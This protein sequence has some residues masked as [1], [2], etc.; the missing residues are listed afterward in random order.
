MNIVYYLISFALLCFNINSAQAFVVD[1]SS[2]DSIGYDNSTLSSVKSNSFLEISNNLPQD[3]VKLAAVHLISS[4]DRLKVITKTPVIKPCDTNI[5][6]FPQG[7]SGTF[8]CNSA[9]S[10]KEGSVTKSGCVNCKSNMTLSNGQCSCDKTKYKYNATNNPCLYGY[11][12]NSADICEEYGPTGVAATYYAACICPAEYQYECTETG[13]IGSG[14]GCTAD[15]VTKYTACICGGDYT[16][17]CSGSSTGTGTVSTPPTNSAH[18]CTATDGTKKYSTCGTTC[19]NGYYATVTDW[20]NQCWCGADEEMV[21]FK[22]DV[23]DSRATGLKH[24][25][26][27]AG[28]ST[29]DWGDGNTTTTSSS[30]STSYDHTYSTAGTYTIKITGTPTAVEGSDDTYQDSIVELVKVNLPSVISYY[31]LFYGADNMTGDLSNVTLH[32]GLVNIS[33]MFTG[34]KVTGTPP[35]LPSSVENASGTYNGA[36]RLTCCSLQNNGNAN[37]A[38]SEDY[39]P[40]Y[41]STIEQVPACSP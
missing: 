40:T 22:V 32:E 5:Y 16:L 8:N 23:N 18:I 4:P 9:Q 2:S 36:C 12:Q 17:T 34:S 31:Q 21:A 11:S 7:S 41:C 29:I 37:F 38:P 3:G 19:G 13:Q 24:F 6:P 25:I 27:I 33:G 28:N 14:A 30:Y 39:C 15:G 26:L 10:C 1:A 20:W 35:D